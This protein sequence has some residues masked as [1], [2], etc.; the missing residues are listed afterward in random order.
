[1]HARWTL[2]RRVSWRNSTPVLRRHALGWGT[3]YQVRRVHVGFAVMLLASCQKKHPS[4]NPQVSEAEAAACELAIETA[5][6]G[7]TAAISAVDPSRVGSDLPECAALSWADATLAQNPQS[8][9][10]WQLLPVPWEHGGMMSVSSTPFPMQIINATEP[11]PAHSPEATIDLAGIAAR[12]IIPK[13]LYTQDVLI[14]LAVAVTPHEI[15]TAHGLRGEFEERPRSV[16]RGFTITT[17]RRWCARGR[18]QPKARR[19]STRKRRTSART[20]C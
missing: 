2:P 6:T 3:V 19:V 15:A 9:H 20:S 16:S 7:W 17:R 8:W 12:K 10:G 4:P 14:R 11:I 13:S 5:D 18:W 1:M